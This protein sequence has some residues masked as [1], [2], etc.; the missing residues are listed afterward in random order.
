MLRQTTPTSVENPLLLTSSSDHAPLADGDADREVRRNA[1]RGDE[2]DERCAIWHR[3]ADALR[4]GVG[5]RNVGHRGSAL[6]L[7]AERRSTPLTSKGEQLP[8]RD[9]DV[10]GW[11]AHAAATERRQWKAVGEQRR[12]AG[13][14]SPDQVVVPNA[15]ASGR[16]ANRERQK[17]TTRYFTGLRSYAARGLTV[18]RV[19][20]THLYA[21][22]DL[23]CSRFYSKLEQPFRALIYLTHPP[24]WFR[25]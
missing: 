5:A 22:I 1:A 10:R 4:V 20:G 15:A 16:E 7:M 12:Q 8:C 9:R 24:L 13:F 18:R 25:F 14:Q 23:T 17:V 3:V 21:R 19:N 6:Q 11:C 2:R